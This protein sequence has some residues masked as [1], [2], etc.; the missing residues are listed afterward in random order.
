MIRRIGI[1][2]LLVLKR[3]DAIKIAAI[4]STIFIPPNN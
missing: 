4:I 3:I 2:G 1:P